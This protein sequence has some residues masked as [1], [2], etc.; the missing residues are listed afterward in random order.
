MT[1]PAEIARCETCKWWG[2]RISGRIAKTDLCRRYPPNPGGGLPVVAHCEFCGEHSPR[3]HMKG[4][5]DE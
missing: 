3:E 2:G 4:K 5:D 1:D